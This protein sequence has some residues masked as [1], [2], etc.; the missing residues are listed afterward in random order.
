MFPRKPAAAA[1]PLNPQEGP[2]QDQS[3]YYGDQ[4]VSEIYLWCTR[5]YPRHWISSYTFSS[6]VFDPTGQDE[7]GGVSIDMYQPFQHL[8]GDD[9]FGSE[10]DLL[11]SVKIMARKVTA[12]YS[13]RS[14]LLIDLAFTRRV[15]V[16]ELVA[17]IVAN[18]LQYYRFNP[19][20]SG[21]LFWQLT[22]INK[23]TAVGWLPPN[24]PQH[25]TG[26]VQNL[27]AR[28]G[29]QAIPFPP[30]QGTFYR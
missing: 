25:F 24:A 28:E 9:V 11:G 20:G 21:C 17:L 26:R 16:S 10:D 27:A 8:Y 15:K 13:S 4:Y 6:Q 1:P 30:A 12:L 23:F 19:A 5:D 29:Q 18:N 14:P 3:Q 7:L 22:L 2:L